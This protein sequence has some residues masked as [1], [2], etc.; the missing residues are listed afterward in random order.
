M[1]PIEEKPAGSGIW[2][3]LNEP[4]CFQLARCGGDP[5]RAHFSKFTCTENLETHEY[6]ITLRKVDR[7]AVLKT[8]AEFSAALDEYWNITRG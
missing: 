5:I 2:Y 1:N 4:C 6:D 3:T 7:Q 8:C